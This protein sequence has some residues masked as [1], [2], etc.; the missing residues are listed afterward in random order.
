[1]AK[2][3]L[4]KQQVLKIHTLGLTVYCETE[5]GQYREECEAIDKYDYDS[6]VRWA[7]DDNKWGHQSL[8]KHDENG[9]TCIAHLPS[10]DDGQSIVSF[11]TG[12]ALAAVSNVCGSINLQMA[13]RTAGVI[14]ANLQ[15]EEIEV[16]DEPKEKEG[17][18]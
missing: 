8:G 3:Y 4:F 10:R 6:Y 15:I 17:K 13:S 9:M 14:F 7:K 1:M 5:C 18:V 16:E 11:C 12:L 2:K